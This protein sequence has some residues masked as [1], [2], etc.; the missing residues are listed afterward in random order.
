M[1]ARREFLAGAS[2]ATAISPAI[3][4]ALDTTEA[5]GAATEIA[6]RLFATRPAPALSF[7]V[8]R[9]DR[10]IWAAAFGF[11]DVELEVP[12]TTRHS[13]PL[14]S[15]SKV[16]TSTAAARLA[17]RGVLDLDMPIVEWLPDLPEQ[18]HKTTIR[19]LLTHRGGI[20]HY[21]PG[22]I[23]LA[24][25]GGAI[26]MRIYPE[27]ADALALFIRDALIAAPGTSVNYSSYGYTLASLAMQAAA[28]RPFRDLIQEEVAR[29]F[30]LASLAA[31]DPW[32]VLSRAGKYMNGRDIEMLAAGLAPAAR[33]QLTNG[34]AKM[35]F[36]NPAYCWSGGGFLMTPSDAARFGAAMI[37]AGQGP[38]SSAERQL[39]FTPVTEAQAGSP[40]LGLG[41]RISPDTKGRLRWHHSGA[42]G[43]G[44]YFLAVY[45]EQQL[46][47]ALAGNVMNARVNMSQVGSEIIDT[48]V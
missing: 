30:N 13:F 8:A 11:A 4:Q 39:L 34:W 45:P 3:A 43:G 25:P 33:P 1:I 23:D 27:D 31:D 7:A 29:P 12:A 42:T 17:S 18:H 47:I 41:W 38:L 9:P 35:A 22:E 46:S 24:H 19:H 32:A 40:P 21:Q 36:C 10:I 37:N 16:V 48:F 44:C 20:R 6:E 15:V 5:G 14:G 28:G 26:Y 2:L